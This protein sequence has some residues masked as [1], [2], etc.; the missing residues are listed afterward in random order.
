ME[1]IA[2]QQN[3]RRDRES[4]DRRAQLEI[5]GIKLEMAEAMIAGL[6]RRKDGR[7]QL[8]HLGLPFGLGE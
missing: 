8:R 2:T 5:R 6:A 4:H 3:Q 7:S 1:S